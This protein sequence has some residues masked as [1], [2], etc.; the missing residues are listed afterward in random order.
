MQPGGVEAGAGG[1]PAGH[2]GVEHEEEGGGDGLGDW[3]GRTSATRLEGARLVS[4]RLEGANFWGALEGARF[5]QARLERANFWEAGLEEADIT[6]ARPTGA[7]F[8]K[9]R[10]EGADLAFAWLEGTNLRYADFRRS[11]CPPRP[12][13]HRR[14]TLLTSEARKT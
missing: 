13:K 2:A 8:W 1:P 5:F 12:T 14:S 10:L 3:K 7:N 9:A 4:A 11:G 6:E